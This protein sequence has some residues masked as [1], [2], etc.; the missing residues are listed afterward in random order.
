M[1]I[2]T[3]AAAQQLGVSQR[4]VQRLAQSGR[5]T[6]RTVAG[7]TIVSGRSLV[8]LSR[9]ATR[10][11]RWND[12]T[13]RAACELLEH[14]NTELI[15]GSQRS[16]LRARLRGVSAAE[17]ALHVLGGRV[18]LWRATG[19][20]VSTMVET[21]AAD[22]LSSTGEGLSVKVTED[23]AAL[24]RRSRLLADNDGNLLVVELA[25]TAPGIVADITQY[26]YGD[27][28]TSSAARRRIEARQ[29]A[30]A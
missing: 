30:L 17:L 9:S 19:Q 4:Q 27:E 15:R 2:T 1:D 22:G 29:A 6:H 25:T 20:S 23:A 18:T 21:D 12:E 26:A 10:G 16:R 7:R 5:V 28:R 11:R 14:G 24:A 3:R 13:V 8:A